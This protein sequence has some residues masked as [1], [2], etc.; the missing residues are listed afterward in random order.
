[1]RNEPHTCG[2]ALGTH[3]EYPHGI[4]WQFLAVQPV[5]LEFSPPRT[6]P[7]TVCNLQPTLPAMILRCQSLAVLALSGI[8]ANASREIFQGE[9]ATAFAGGQDI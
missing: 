9:R 1:M 4:S 5:P 7:T 8:Q 2:W 6:S 3:K